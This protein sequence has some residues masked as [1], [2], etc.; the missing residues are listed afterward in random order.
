MNT[1]IVLSVMVTGW[2]ILFT[3]IPRAPIASALISDDTCSDVQLVF[4]RGSGQTLESGEYDRF[5]TQVIK[6]INESFLT[7][8]SYELGTEAYNSFQ[9]P[10]IDVADV[11]NGNAIGAK[12]SAG[13]ANDYGDSVKQGVGELQAYLSKRVA[14][15]KNIKIILGGYSQGA[16]V[17]GQALIDM[18]EHIRSNIV[19]TGLFGDPKLYLPEGKGMSPPACRGAEFSS[20]RRGVEECATDNGSL[21]ARTPYLPSYAEQSTGLW[22]NAN[23]FVCGSSKFVWDQEGHGSYAA[24]NG[25]IDQAAIEAARRLKQALPS[26]IQHAVAIN[27]TYGSTQYGLDAVFFVDL[28]V[29]SPAQLEETKQA[30]RDALTRIE[31]A[32]GRMAVTHYADTASGSAYAIQFNDA[33]TRYGFV[34]TANKAMTPLEAVQAQPLTG[35]VNFFYYIVLGETIDF[36]DWGNGRMKS[37]VLITQRDISNADPAYDGIREYIRKRSLEIDPVNIYPVIAAEYETGA[38]ATAD[39]TGGRVYTFNTSAGS[40]A[41]SIASVTTELIE[42]PIV[43]FSNSEYLA[44]P[45]E[46]VRFDVSNSYAVDSSIES[47]D[48]D[49]N[50]DGT[51]DRQTTEPFVEHVY[52][53]AYSGLAHARA[54]AANAMTGSMT[55]AVTVSGTDIRPAITPPPAHSVVTAEKDIASEV[56]VSWERESHPSDQLVSVNGI[57]IGRVAQ[58]TRSVTITDLDR[59]QEVTIGIRSIDESGAVSEEAGITLAA[60]TPIE[61]LPEVTPPTEPAADENAPPSAPMTVIGEAAGSTPQQHNKTPRAT[62]GRTSDVLLAYNL[63]PQNTLDKTQEEPTAAQEP[64]SQSKQETTQPATTGTTHNTQTWI[65]PAAIAI[66]AAFAAAC[67]RWIQKRR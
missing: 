60:I 34:T 29:A 1:R 37:L 44:K 9:Y 26:N 20:W 17:I 19:F 51:W 28:N 14:N 65:M 47:Y 43:V 31:Q 2:A 55:T 61:P 5:R 15:C 38:T 49:F 53:E 63:T 35:G 23:D 57:T 13:M 58:D 18:P 46:V 42:R 11:S 66:G 24:D 67:Y 36:L 54:R 39:S 32:G 59:T 40:L 22:C 48:W 30:V 8:K 33:G 7:V 41:D 3:C 50:G 6:R 56:I 45:G 16:Q 12:L 4:A 25:A 27:R 52:D 10:A 62:I 21:S 64:I